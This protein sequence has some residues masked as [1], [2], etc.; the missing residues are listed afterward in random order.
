MYGFAGRANQRE[1]TCHVGSVYKVKPTN[2]YD[3]PL[4]ITELISFLRK[5]AR[6]IQVRFSSGISPETTDVK[7]Y[8]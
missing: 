8:I 7:R 1:I 4:S 3:V 6:T 5:A 2:T